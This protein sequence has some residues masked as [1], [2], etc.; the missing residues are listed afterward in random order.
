MFVL[1]HCVLSS[2]KN[3]LKINIMCDLSLKYIFIHSILMH[4]TNVYSFDSPLCQN[5]FL[6]QQKSQCMNLERG[7]KGI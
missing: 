7:V 1:F 2:K 4:I 3:H 5:I 6:N